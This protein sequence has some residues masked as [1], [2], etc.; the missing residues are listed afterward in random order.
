MASCGWLRLSCARDRAG[1]GKAGLGSARPG[2]AGQ[3]KEQATAGRG[4]AGLG[5]AWPG[6]E[7]GR[8][9]L[10]RAWLGKAGRGKEQGPTAAKQHERHPMTIKLHKQRKPADYLLRRVPPELH[11]KLRLQSLNEDRTM[12][13]IILEA[14]E[15]AT[16]ER[17]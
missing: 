8:A 17:G 7:R 14:L 11:H 6:K 13:E 16:K 5:E 15:V 3:G 12:R 1:S 9:G 4:K 2:K 10:G